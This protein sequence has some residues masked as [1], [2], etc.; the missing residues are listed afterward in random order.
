MKTYRVKM[1]I[2]GLDVEVS[3]SPGETLLEV[4]RERLGRTDVKAGCGKGDC[5]ACAVLVDGMAVNSCLTLAM[6]ANGKEVITLAG[7]GTRDTPH[8]LQKSF[9]E[10]GAVQ[11]GF[12]TSGM[13]VSAKA[14]L[15]RNPQPNRDEIR[16]AISG[17]LCRCTGYRKIV[18]AIQDAASGDRR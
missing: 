15:D 2:N 11:C 17:N 5:G 12:C 9:V 16:E 14:L 6:Q 1:V 18:E 7:I 8:P 10:H 3:V 13:V 4:L